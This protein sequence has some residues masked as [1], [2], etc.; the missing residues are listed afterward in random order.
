VLVV[1]RRRVGMKE[2]QATKWTKREKVP[3]EVEKAVSS[4]G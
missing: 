4:C 3:T 1:E 2:E